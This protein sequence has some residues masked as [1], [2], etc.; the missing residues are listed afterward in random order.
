MKKRIS[1]TL[2]TRLDQE[3]YHLSTGRESGMEKEKMGEE[4]EEEAK[5]ERERIGRERS[6]REQRKGRKVGY[7]YAWTRKALWIVL[8]AAT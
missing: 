6:Q 3:T 5:G 7:T 8:T 4:T 2:S 1:L